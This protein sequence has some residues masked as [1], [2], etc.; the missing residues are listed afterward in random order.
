MKL[1][2]KIE[3][4]QALLRIS[5]YSITLE[6]ES[7]GALNCDWLKFWLL[8]SGRFYPLKKKMLFFRGIVL[9]I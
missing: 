2:K 5:Q 9:E 6:S 1:F 7:I 8:G 3:W 4:N